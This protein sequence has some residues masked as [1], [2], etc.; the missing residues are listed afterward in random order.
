MP[1][2]W[3][4]TAIM[5]EIFL[6][7]KPA[8]QAVMATQQWDISVKQHLTLTDK[9]W[10]IL[11]QLHVFFKIFVLPT[12]RSQADKY[13]ALHETILNFIGIIG[14]LRE[15]RREG[16]NLAIIPLCSCMC[17]HR[18]MDKKCEN[19]RNARNARNTRNTRNARNAKHGM[20]TLLASNSRRSLRN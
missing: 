8:I 19:A 14:Q 12:S 4:P 3:S 1:V 20:R 10:A 17:H 18:E 16:G 13:P 6:S 7:M 11:E 5:L 15:T 9:D 2:R